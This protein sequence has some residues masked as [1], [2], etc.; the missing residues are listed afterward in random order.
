V[1]VTYNR[2]PARLGAALAGARLT[3][4]LTL[5]WD[6]VDLAPSASA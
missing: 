6:Y 1:G 3:E 4:I 5:R 2:G